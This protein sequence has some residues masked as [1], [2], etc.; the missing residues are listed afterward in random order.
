MNQGA[1][2]LSVSSVSLAEAEARADTLRQQL[3][4]ASHAY[5]VLAE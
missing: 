3:N 5:Y 4:Q 1:P 2:T